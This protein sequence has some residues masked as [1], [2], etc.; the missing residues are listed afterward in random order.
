MAHHSNSKLS[1]PFYL[2]THT[3]FLCLSLLCHQAAQLA[4]VIDDDREKALK[5]VVVATT[6]ENCKATI[7][8]EK[9]AQEAE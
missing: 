1:Y 4:Y 5:D 7:V 9:R 8:S 6:K 2:C 3:F